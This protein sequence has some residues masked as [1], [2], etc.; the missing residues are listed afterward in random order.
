VHIEY[1]RGEI[2]QIGRAIADDERVIKWIRTREKES[3]SEQ[4]SFRFSFNKA[5]QEAVQYLEGIRELIPADP[6]AYYTFVGALDSAT[7]GS[8]LATVCAA[9]YLFLKYIDRPEEALTTAVNIFGSDTDTISVFLGGLLGAHHGMS[10]VPAHLSL[11]IQDRDCLLKVARRLH[12]IAAGVQREQLAENQ[13]IDR[14]EAYLRILAWEIGLLDMFWDAIDIGGVVTHPTLGRGSI[15]HK[16]V[17]PIKREGYVAK[18]ISVQFDCGQSC[19]FHSRVE[20]NEKVSESL[21]QDVA[22]ALE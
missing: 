5:R 17:K 3:R 19:I 20:N 22:K 9:I 16:T 21:A 8:G 13:P 11:K 14:T 10:A 7:K 1:V 15:T 18:L 4:S 6:K 2:E 12:S